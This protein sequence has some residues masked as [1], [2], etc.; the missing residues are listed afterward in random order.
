MGKQW[1]RALALLRDAGLIESS[2]QCR[3]LAARCLAEVSDWDDVLNV[4]G[5]WDETDGDVIGMQV[6]FQL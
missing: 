3:Y 4:L 6:L 1:R 5:G 2:L